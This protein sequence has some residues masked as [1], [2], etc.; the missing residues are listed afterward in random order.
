[1][2]AMVVNDDAGKLMS[3]VVLMIIAS[4]LA[5]TAGQRLELAPFTPVNGAFVCRKKCFSTTRGSIMRAVIN[6]PNEQ[7][8]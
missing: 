6:H 3:R 2:F 4:E 7:G 5:P 8:E 1:M